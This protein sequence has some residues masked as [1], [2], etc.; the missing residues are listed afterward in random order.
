MLLNHPF[1][2]GGSKSMFTGRRMPFLCRA[3][4]TQRFL[5]LEREFET[6]VREA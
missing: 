6:L 4:D 1:A 2:D 3:C 5:K